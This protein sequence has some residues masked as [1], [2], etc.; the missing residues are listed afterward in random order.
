MEDQIRYTPA[1]KS[2]AIAIQLLLEESG[3]PSEDIV[4]HLGHFILARDSKKILGCIGVEV[5]GEI[6]FIRSLAVEAAFRNRGTA[7]DLYRECEKH[8]RFL[9]MRDLYLLTITAETFFAKRGWTRIDR[10]KAPEVICRT[11]EFKGLCPAS[12]I[13]MEK[14]NSPS[15]MG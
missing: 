1:A 9:G 14:R 4:R 12:A 8:A 2:D 3:L 15:P 10:G 11:E 5:H 6:G 7:G 13:C